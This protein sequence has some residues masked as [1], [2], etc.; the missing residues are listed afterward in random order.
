MEDN[1]AVPALSTVETPHPK[2]LLAAPLHTIILVLIVVLVSLAG[3]SSVA[4]GLARHGRIR[5]YAFT[6][7]Y[8]VVL[9][10]WVWLGVRRRGGSIR[11]LIA[12]RWQTPE[13]FLLD[14][15]IAGG[16]WL[17][18]LGVLAGLAF[19][20]GLAG[21]AET[22]AARKTLFA[23]APSTRG[24]LALFVGLSCVAGFVEEIVFRG[25]LQRQLA[26]LAAGSAV[27]GIAAS[28]IVFGLSHGY[29]GPKR[30]V[31]I[32]VYGMLFGVLAHWRKS[33]RPGMIAH[34]WHDAISGLFLRLM[35]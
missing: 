15:A 29:E 20:F 24:E 8:E 11:E 1:A 10:G 7:V 12:G 14:V 35:K 25:Y 19:A 5:T 3:S 31:L 34:A 4:S 21:Q 9:L 13:D 28:G 18:A 6:I 30:M 27:I 23:L 17:V 33:L 32:A 26:T 22:D 2:P 16:Y